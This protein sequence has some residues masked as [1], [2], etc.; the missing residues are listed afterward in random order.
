MNPNPSLN[1]SIA[2]TKY[3]IKQNSGRVLVA[4]PGLVMVDFWAVASGVM[5]VAL[6]RRVV[7]AFTRHGGS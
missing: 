5:S 1:G 7:S 3:L 2:D 6:G 4:T